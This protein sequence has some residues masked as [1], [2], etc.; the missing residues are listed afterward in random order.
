[1]SHYWK[2]DDPDAREGLA[3]STHEKNQSVFFVTEQKH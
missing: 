3:P 2:R 1:M